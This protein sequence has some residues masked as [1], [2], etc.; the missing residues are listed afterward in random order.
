MV[1]M[2]S[3]II[4]EKWK[5]EK[6]IKELGL[7]N[8]WPSAEYSPQII[9]LHWQ[10]TFFRQGCPQDLIGMDQTLQLTKWQ[11]VWDR[12][13]GITSN[14]FQLAVSHR[15]HMCQILGLFGGLQ[16]TALSLPLSCSGHKISLIKWTFVLFAALVFFL[17][18]ETF[19]LIIVQL[20]GHS[21][22]YLFSHGWQGLFC[23]LIACN[24]CKSSNNV[25]CN[26]GWVNLWVGGGW[27]SKLLTFGYSA[28]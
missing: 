27:V 24:S 3:L 8:L 14:P 25:L 13:T 1:M 22:L 17:K 28:S 7:K 9:I 6:G 4:N 12:V 11:T 19:L 5:K 15:S 26:G 18:I 21:F 20:L 2:L 10:H 23:L 16:D